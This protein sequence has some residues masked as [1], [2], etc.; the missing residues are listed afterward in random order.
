MENMKDGEHLRVPRGDPFQDKWLI[1]LHCIHDA[2]SIP[3]LCIHDLHYIHNAWSIP[4]ICIHDLHYI[5]DA[6]SIPLLCIHDDYIQW[7]QC[8]GMDHASVTGWP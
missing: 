6:W 8:N 7:M 1:S 4:L 5:H 3:L 2:W